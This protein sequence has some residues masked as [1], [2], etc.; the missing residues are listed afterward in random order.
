MAVKKTAS[1]KVRDESASKPKAGGKKSAAKK[2]A[3]APKKSETAANSATPKKTAAQKAAP[4]VKLTAS[5]SDLLKRIGEAP[6]PGYRIEKKA[7]QR[8][9]DA[10]QER[11]LIKKGSKHKE[12]GNYHYLISSLGK[13]HLESQSGTPSQGVQSQPGTP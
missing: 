9:L 4:P 11:K 3:V 12:S 8:T 7:E 2:E 6:E 10:L 1:E 13:K 5:Q